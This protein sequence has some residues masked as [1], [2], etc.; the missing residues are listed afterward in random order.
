M[1]PDEM[2]APNVL[3]GA[4]VRCYATL[5]GIEPSGRLLVLVDGVPIAKPGAVAVC[6]YEGEDDFYLLHC[7]A[8]WS[9]LGAGHYATLEIARATAE[10]AYPGVAARWV[11][12][13]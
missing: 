2:H 7:G 8:D 9:V 5:V 1:K 6:Q 12:R 4:Q 13:D 10:Y 11:K 3:D